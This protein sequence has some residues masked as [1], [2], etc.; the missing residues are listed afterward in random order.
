MEGN[1]EP[2][3]RLLLPPVRS[4]KVKEGEGQPEGGDEMQ[5]TIHFL[6]FSKFGRAERCMEINH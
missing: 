4:S 2:K 3:L 6:A 1:E 5:A